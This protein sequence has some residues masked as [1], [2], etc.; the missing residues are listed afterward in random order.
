MLLKKIG[1]IFLK[2]LIGVFAFVFFIIYVVIPIGAPLVIQNQGSKILKHPVDVRSVWLN[3]FLLRLS[4]DGFKI[5]DPDTKEVM[6][7]F[8]KFW[9]DVS[10]ISLLKKEYRVE[11]AGLDGLVVNAALLAGNRVNLMDIVP[12]PAPAAS[13]SVPLA[14]AQPAPQNPLPKA[15]I[16]KILLTNGTVTFTDRTVSPE[17][18]TKLSGMTLTVTG[19]STEPG[20]VA[21]AVFSTR[22]DDQGVISAE[23]N[24]KPLSQPLEMETAFSLN[25]YSLT[26]LTP[27]VGK[28]T[29]RGVKTGKMDLT[30]NYKIAGNKLTAR[31]KL[32]IQKFDFGTKVE[33]KDA[34][35]LPFGLAVALLEDPQGRISI[36]LPV[37]GDMSDPKFEYFHLIGQV[38]GNFFMKLV[39]APFMALLSFVGPDTGTEEFAAVTFEPGRAELTDKAKETLNLF[40]KVLKERPKLSVEVNGSYD[41]LADWKAMKIEAYVAEFVKKRSDSNRPDFRL[42]EDMYKVRFGV[43]GYWELAREYTVDQVINE[44]ALQEEMRRQ[45]I[46]EGRPDHAALDILGQS[47]AK[48]VY[49]RII[50]GGFD[51]ARIKL[52]VSRETQVSMGLVPM[53]FTMTVYEK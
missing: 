19:I 28:Y 45:I 3:P 36:S 7:G 30:M 26:V 52:G 13:P 50:A 51:P 42:V 46:E 24:V 22:L 18:L 37:K 32:L 12:V 29:G 6:F 2:I 21:N 25:D 5:L 43:T 8:S 16:D 1:Q 27:Y 15:R 49:D 41:P 20:S 33:S 53:E 38:A 35:N 9:V 44:S 23:T 11:S 31:H 48:A 14:P 34:L 40:V 17:F 39:T 4:V 10:F 47:R